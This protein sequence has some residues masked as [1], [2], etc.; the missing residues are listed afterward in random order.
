[1][2]KFFEL[3]KHGT[4]VPTEIMAGFTTFFAMSYILFVNPTLLSSTGMPRG[5]VYMATI[6]SAFIGTLFMGL[7]ANVPYAVAPGMGL[8]AF[9][10]YTVVMQL[11]FT[12]QQA[13]AMVF[14]CGVINII[15]TITNIRKAIIAAIPESL[16]HAIGGGIGCFIAYL[17]LVNAG[18]V[19][20]TPSDAAGSTALIPTLGSF[21]NPVVQVSLIGLVITIVLLLL[22][23]KGAILIGI[24]SSTLIGL[25]P[26]FSVTSFTGNEANSFSEIFAGLGQT[27]GAAFG[28][29]GIQ[30]LFT[31]GATKT[32]IALVTIFSFSLSDTFD[33]IGTFIG[34]GR[35]S[36]I[37]TEEDERLMQEKAGFSTRLDK[38]LFADS[39]AT[40]IGA[41]FGTS[42]ATTYV[43][44]TAGIGAG[45]RTGLTS[46]VV[47]ILFALCTFI[48][49]LAG[50][51]PAAATA[52][53]LIIVGI[54]M[55]SSFAQLL[56]EDFAEAV[57]AFFAAIFMAFSYSI[58][59]G[60]AF[61]FF[62][63]IL[64]KVAKGKA[65]EI[66][67]ILWVSSILFILNYIL[68]AIYH[69]A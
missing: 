35:N 64:V 40:S 29:E 10:T 58:S 44:S 42:N 53:A 62:A 57:P 69:T 65:K 60:I 56:W 55:L 52:P 61:G 34:T 26:V 59:H 6:L 4:N 20:N 48:G 14:I 8:N 33:T 43:E 9:F 13:L 68:I 7:F 12:W 11:G 63:Y 49:P 28:K 66:H 50:A 3:K 21:A 30:S 27:F 41:L 1:M 45:G 15:I 23:V 36:G 18:I 67:P 22:N 19:H 24:L 38:A 32:V 25:L 46:V 2:E 31:Q 5:G 16:Q 39:I 47:A 51:V 54:M 37:F 17:G